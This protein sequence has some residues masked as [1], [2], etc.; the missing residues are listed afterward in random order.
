MAGGHD[1]PAFVI[2]REL[3]CAAKHVFDGPKAPICSHFFPLGATIEIGGLLCQWSCPR[4]FSSPTKTYARKRRVR[5]VDGATT[6]AM[7]LI[8]QSVGS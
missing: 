7:R 1:H 5:A 6:G 2:H 8:D 3:C 4:F